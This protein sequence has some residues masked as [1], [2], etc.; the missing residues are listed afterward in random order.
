MTYSN[1]TTILSVV[2]KII[3][4]ILII[5]II[6]EM[7]FFPSWENFCGCIMTFIC[8]YIFDHFFLLRAIILKYPFAFIMYTSMFLYRFLPLPATLLENKPITYGLQIPYMTFLF[9]TLLFIVSS[10]AF[11]FSFSLNRK[12]NKLQ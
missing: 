1:N 4:L 3:R 9:E 5:S 12:N 6:S 2:K 10:F 8:W 7:I 11:R